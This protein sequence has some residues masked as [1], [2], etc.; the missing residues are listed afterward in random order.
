MTFRNFIF[1]FTLIPKLLFSQSDDEYEVVGF[2]CGFAGMSSKPVTRV[3]ELL[4]QKDYV[5]V[6]KLLKSNN[7]AE[8]YLAVI[9][10]ERLSQLSVYKPSIDEVRLIA[11]IKN[12]REKVSVC[13]GCTYFETMSLKQ[14]FDSPNLIRRRHWLNEVLPKGEVK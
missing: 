10:V 12:S 7:N 5:A 8:K 6:A 2:A 3:S 11:S 14:L 1:V 9:I 13:S 4:E